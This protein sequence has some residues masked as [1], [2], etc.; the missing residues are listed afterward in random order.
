MTKAYTLS[1]LLDGGWYDHPT[2]WLTL[3]FTGLLDKN[4]KE[5][6]E[7]DIIALGTK[8]NG[9]VFFDMGRF[10]VR[11]FYVPSFDDPSDAFGEGLPILEVIGN[12]YET[13]DLLS[14]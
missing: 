14:V 3:Q 4:G 7:G 6:Y 9:D 2:D 5:I 13:P 8:R 1:E 11:D 10:W 12:L